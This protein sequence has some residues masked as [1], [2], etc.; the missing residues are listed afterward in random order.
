MVSAAMSAPS[1]GS[2]GPEQGIAPQYDCPECQYSRTGV[3]TSRHGFKLHLL[4]E[5]EYSIEDV[6][7]M[8]SPP[9]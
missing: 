2:W 9:G 1:E 3:A 5:H 6:D 4:K 8:L 7:R